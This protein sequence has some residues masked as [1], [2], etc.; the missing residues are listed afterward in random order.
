MNPDVLEELLRESQYN[1]VKSKFLVEGF[2]RGFPISYAGPVNR[3]DYSNNIPCRVGSKTEMWNK[4]MKEVKLKRFAS[5]Y[6]TI[7]FKNFIQSPI[8]LVPKHDNQTRL[9]FHLSY[10]FKDSGGK[11]VNSHIPKEDCKTKYRDLD[12]AVKLGL[13]LAGEENL[14][15]FYGK[16]DLEAAFRVL[17]LSRESYKWVILRA[18]DPETGEKW[19]FIEKN[20]PF[21]SSISCS[22]F[23]EFSD[24]LRNIVEFKTRSPVALT[25]YLDDFLFTATTVRKCN[26]LI[27]V[28]LDVCFEIGVPVAQKK[29]VWGCEEIIFLGIIL[30]GKEKLLKI[31]EDKRTKALNMLCWIGD[32]KKAKVGDLEKLSGFLNFLT[33]AIFPGRAFTRRMYAK[34][35]GLENLKKHHHIKLDAEFKGDCQ[36]WR[37]FLDTNIYAKVCRPFVDLS[38]K[39]TAEQ[40]NMYSDAS[41]NEKYGIGSYLERNFLFARWEDNFIRRCN[42]SIEFMELLGICVGVFAWS[43]QLRNKRFILYTDNTSARDVINSTSTSGKYSMKLIRKLTLRSLQYNFRVFAEY[44]EGKNNEIADSLS[45]IKLGRIK[46]L[47]EKGI[48]NKYPTTLPTELWPPSQFWEESD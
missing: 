21:G 23:Q 14:P 12:F 42:P 5:P 25:N 33:K 26:Y 44:V 40:L 7:P 39:L 41:G 29:T 32:K 45:R 2:R 28:F 10:D 31:P 18:E 8:G 3:Q 30:N 46:E 47:Q 27:K 17:P 37:E 20:L 43:E 13:R 11:S 24:S 16:T 48:L 1:T 38:F 6:K 9:I 36:V 35:T 34:F 4:V 19:F 15:L 22:H